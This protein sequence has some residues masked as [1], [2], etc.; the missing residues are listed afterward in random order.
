MFWTI[1]ISR[2]ELKLFNAPNGFCTYYSIISHKEACLIL[3]LAPLSS[4]LILKYTKLESNRKKKRKSIKQMFCIFLLIIIPLS[5]CIKTTSFSFFQV[6]ARMQLKKILRFFSDNTH[7]G[8]TVCL[9]TPMKAFY[10]IHSGSV[11]NGPELYIL[12]YER[13]MSKSPNS[14]L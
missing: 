8:A 2:R 7:A 4:I 1:I 5:S 12:H 13:P 3:N 14:Y 11:I 10:H 9:C 6:T